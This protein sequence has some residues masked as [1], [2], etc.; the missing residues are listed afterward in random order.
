MDL[1][2]KYNRNKYGLKSS[3]DCYRNIKGVHY[4]NYSSDTSPGAY[5]QYIDECKQLGLKWKIIKNEF[6]REV[7]L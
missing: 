5:K 4:E 2:P 7:K 6:Y 3:C 1:K